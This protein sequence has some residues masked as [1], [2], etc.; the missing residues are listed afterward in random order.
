[1]WLYKLVNRLNGNFYI[2]VTMNLKARMKLHKNSKGTV[3]ICNAIKKYGW[4]NFDLFILRDDIQTKEEMFRLEKETIALLNPPYNETEGGEGISGF[5]HSD[6]T[7]KKMSESAKNV[8]RKPLSI[9]H[10]LNISKGCKGKLKGRPSKS[11]LL[12]MSLWQKGKKKGPCSEETKRK[13]SESNMGNQN[14]L[15]KKHSEETKR[16]MA[17]SRRRVA[18]QKRDNTTIK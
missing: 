15:G 8:T 12:N 2:G 4:E 1:M 18:K 13:I 11:H 10:R 6:Q 3:T 9:E 5:K 17:E 14:M 16:K 7:K